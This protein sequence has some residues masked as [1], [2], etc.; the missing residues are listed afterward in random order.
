[1]VKGMSFTA[2]DLVVGGLVIWWLGVVVAWFRWLEWWV[3]DGRVESEED[4]RMEYSINIL[5][6]NNSRDL[7]EKFYTL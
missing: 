4:M 1:M 2:G 7:I 6:F 3:G 5:F